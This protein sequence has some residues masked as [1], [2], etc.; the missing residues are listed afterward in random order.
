MDK[1]HFKKQKKKGQKL[2]LV[3]LKQRVNSEVIYDLLLVLHPILTPWFLLHRARNC[4]F[5][6]YL[7]K[8]SVVYVSNVS[9]AFLEIVFSRGICLNFKIYFLI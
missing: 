7:L 4:S 5:F 2:L 6:V 9:V 3:C 8:L 1:V